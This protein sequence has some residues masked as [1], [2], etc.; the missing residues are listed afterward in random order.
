MFPC[1]ITISRLGLFVR[2]FDVET[3]KFIMNNFCKDGVL[4][5]KKEA[6]ITLRRL[7]KR[8]YKVEPISD[9][10]VKEV[11]V[12]KEEILKY[13]P[14]LRTLC[15]EAYRLR[16]FAGIWLVLTQQLSAGLFYSISKMQAKTN[17]AVNA[18]NNQYLVDSMISFASFFGRIKPKQ[19]NSS[20]Y[21]I[22]YFFDCLIEIFPA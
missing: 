14:S 9:L 22:S 8:M 5:K 15:I 13:K 16:V 19:N 1:L 21:Q 17:S 6:E 4:V 7:F 11:R 3:P 10:I 18:A 2:V 12:F 20:F